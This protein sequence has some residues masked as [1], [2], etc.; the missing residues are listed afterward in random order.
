LDELTEFFFERHFAE[1]RV[2][3]ALDLGRCKLAVRG[4]DDGVMLACLRPGG[5]ENE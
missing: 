3:L 4:R 5:S 2:N 1:E